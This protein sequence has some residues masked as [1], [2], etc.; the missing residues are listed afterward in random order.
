MIRDIQVLLERIRAIHAA[1][2]D[3]VVSACEQATT[4]QLAEIVAEQAGDTV[5][6]IDRVSE[7]V[8]LEHFAQ[9]G[10]EWS[11]VLIAEGLGKDGLAV[12]PEGTDPAQAE[13]RIIIDP[14]DGTRG[15]MYQKRAAWILTGVAPNLGSTTNLAD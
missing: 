14:I 12:F 2:R 1:M 4:E 3:K 11:F 13:L 8:L 10:Q 5:F 15:L 6:A 9:L 7:E